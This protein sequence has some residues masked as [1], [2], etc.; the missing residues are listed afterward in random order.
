MTA[1]TGHRDFARSIVETLEKR[2]LLSGNF[3][4][5]VTFGVD[6]SISSGN[7]I[8]TDADGSVYVAGNFQRSIDL[9]PRKQVKQT[10]VSADKSQDVFLAKYNAS[11][12]LVWA[13]RF[14]GNDDD[15]AQAITLGPDGNIFLAGTFEKNAVF[16]TRTITSNGRRDAFVA[17]ISPDGDVRWV[18]KVGGRREDYAN[19]IAVD[20]NGDVF[21]S[22]TIRIQGRVN[23]AGGTQVITAR[24]VDAT[25][26]SRLSGDDG[27]LQWIR[28]Y[29]EADTYESAQSL[30]PDGDGGVYVLGMFNRMVQFQPGNARFT[31]ESV[32]GADI[33]LG[34]INSAGNWDSLSTFGGKGEDNAVALAFGSGGLYVTGMFDEDAD[35][36]PSTRARILKPESD[37]DIFIARYSTAGKL[38]WARQI[39]GEDGEVLSR[40]LAVDGS[41]NVYATGTFSDEVDLDPGKG[42]LVFDADKDG[43]TRAVR[44]PV[45]PAPF[46]LQS[47]DASDTFILKLDSRGILAYARVIGG[48]DGSIE[49]RGISVDSAGAAYI[50]GTFAGE[51]DLNPGIAVYRRETDDD[52]RSNYVF[53]LKL[54]A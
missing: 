41:G 37:R 43:G 13:Q 12:K 6:K 39:G 2:Q 5:A 45:T 44:Q 38:T 28:H 42:K 50:T 26:V 19:A 46:I 3:E 34:H 16:G 20:A 9:D 33:Y 24:G 29:G 49:G 52:K 48:E 35:F 27:S 10:L 36:D 8:V 22:G 32:G 40:G 31:R 14:G 7:A 21:L 1:R 51:V 54:D 17:R 11:G 4:W 30:A 23:P 18:G 15:T 53:L 47:G 25:Y